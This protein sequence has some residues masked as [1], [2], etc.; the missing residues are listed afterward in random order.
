MKH[1]ITIVIQWLLWHARVSILTMCAQCCW[2]AYR[3]KEQEVQGSRLAQLVCTTVHKYSML[4]IHCGTAVAHI[5]DKFKML[6]AA[7]TTRDVNTAINIL[8]LSLIWASG[9]PQLPEIK[10]AYQ[11]LLQ[12]FLL[13]KFKLWCVVV[14]LMPISGTTRQHWY[15]CLQ[16]TV[17]W[18]DVFCLSSV[19]HIV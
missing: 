2:C 15:P 17:F 16:L 9:L 3:L 12:S 18:S 10:R 1:R 5:R 14:L 8:N 13:G 19:P 6:I 4:L 11:Q 7:F